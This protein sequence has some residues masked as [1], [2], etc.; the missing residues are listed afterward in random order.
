M[1]CSPLTLA[2]A[3]PAPEESVSVRQALE[4]DY[5]SIPT[6]LETSVKSSKAPPAKRLTSSSSKTAPATC[7]PTSTLQATSAY[8]AVSNKQGTIHPI[9]AELTVMNGLSLA[10]VL[11]LCS[12]RAAI[13]TINAWVRQQNAL[14]SAPK[15]Y[16]ALD[17]VTELLDLSNIVTVTTQNDASATVVQLWAQ[18]NNTYA[19]WYY[20]PTLNNGAN[21]WAWTPN[22]AFQSSLPTGTQTAAVYGDSFANTM[23]VQPASDSTNVFQIQNSS[24]TTLVNA[25]TS[26]QNVTVTGGSG[27]ASISYVNSWNTHT[28]LSSATYVWSSSEP[29]PS[30]KGDL[31]TLA[32]YDY[33]STV[34]VDSISG[35]GVGSNWHYV[36]SYTGASSHEE[37]WQGTV[38]TT[39]SSS[40]TVN[41]SSAP[42]AEIELVA[43]EFDAGLGPQT[44]WT[45]V[46]SGSKAN[47]SNTQITYPTL[48]S[49]AAGELYF[50]Y[51]ADQQAGLTDQTGCTEGTCGYTSYGDSTIYNTSLA[52]ST[53]YIPT[54]A[55]SPAG[56]S[57]TIA[58]IFE[59]SSTPGLT[60]NGNSLVTG[61]NSV[62][63]FQV[64]DSSGSSIFD[65]DTS[66]DTVTMLQ[67]ARVSTYND[68]YQEY[69]FTLADSL[70]SP[71]QALRLRINNGG[72]NIES[73]GTD[74]WISGF[75]NADFSGSQVYFARGDLPTGDLFIGNA[76][77][78]GTSNSVSGDD[79]ATQLVLDSTA[80]GTTGDPTSAFNGSMYYNTH[81]NEF[82]CYQNGE[83]R[84]C[85]SA[86]QSWNTSGAASTANTSST[87]Y[88]NYPGTS[89]VSFTKAASSTN[90]V[91]SISVD[92][93]RSSSTAGMIDIA[94]R[95]AGT[96]H[97]CTKFFFNAQNTHEQISCS[98]I[99]TGVSAGSQTAQVRWREDPGSSGCTFNADSDTWTTMTVQE[100]D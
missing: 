19:S 52:A 78:D 98:V 20:A 4:L 75:P 83:W 3:V 68:G 61:V 80:S 51:S 30:T 53:Q 12:T 85:V 69:A 10:A 95:I 9:Q 89:S 93:W 76:A 94:V 70:A 65:V 64:Q 59:P 15:V 32:V 74:L 90:L 67:N 63:A 42:N 96:D 37:L 44:G 56:T 47:G 54:G 25:D 13:P 66:A 21:Q 36:D 73:A 40:V 16:L 62:S 57:N 86:V 92:P 18:V 84:N 34:A 31:M 27:G 26:N 82:R 6:L 97:F 81:M 91:A 7:W 35:G 79:G 87:S 58:A 24:G 33:S 17:G 1:M 41:F 77:M 43:Y 39:G 100:T 28:S 38:S 99:V 48:T 72:A 55:Q 23:L 46:T 50:G 49:T 8:K 22:T 11:S 88:S 71:N 60:V 29:S 5:R 45:V 2:T 14:G